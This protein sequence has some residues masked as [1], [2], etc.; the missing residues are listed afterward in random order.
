MVYRLNSTMTKTSLFALQGIRGALTTIVRID[1]AVF[2]FG[3]FGRDKLVTISFDVRLVQLQCKLP[4][5]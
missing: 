3:M 1:V 5:L 2:N 4:K